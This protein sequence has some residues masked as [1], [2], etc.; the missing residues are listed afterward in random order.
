MSSRKGR[1]EG[2][3]ALRG[4]KDEMEMFNESYR[5]RGKSRALTESQRKGKAMDELHELG[6]DDT[7]LIAIM[8]LFKNDADTADMFVAMKH[9]S[10]WKIW[11]EQQLRE[12]GL[13][14]VPMGED[15]V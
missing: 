1:N 12:L 10:T 7:H 6:L 9:Q 4:I 8:Q 14:D 3:T 11:I 5:E 13:M 2:S 15:V